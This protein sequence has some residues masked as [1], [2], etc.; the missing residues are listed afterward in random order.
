[1]GKSHDDFGSGEWPFPWD[2]YLELRKGASSSALT[3]DAPPTTKRSTLPPAPPITEPATAPPSSRWTS[4]AGASSRANQ[5]IPSAP[6]VGPCSTTRRKLEL[7]WQDNS[8]P[9]THI[10]VE[11]PAAESRR[12]TAVWVAAIVMVM[13]LLVVLTLQLPSFAMSE[14]PRGATEPRKSR[15]AALAGDGMK[16]PSE[17][18]L[19]TCSGPA[20]PL[21]E[22]PPP[23][24]GGASGAAT[25][26]DV[27]MVKTTAGKAAKPSTERSSRARPTAT[28]PPAPA[29]ASADREPVY[30][31]PEPASPRAPAPPATEGEIF[32]RP[33][34][35]SN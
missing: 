33:S 8:A 28:Q 20:A 2:P 25:A 35:S 3:E 31:D 9:P 13:G 19:E 12:R 32:N 24:S 34:V 22:A 10:G 6:T 29:R 26:V 17:V 14:G 1:M 18:A 15:P 16:P 11:P 27:Q 23:R 4:L 21:S 5:S 30:P 7:P